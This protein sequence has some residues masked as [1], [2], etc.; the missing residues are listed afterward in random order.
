[1]R[2]QRPCRRLRWNCHTDVK[3]NCARYNT[4][5]E[6]I[7]RMIG[8]APLRSAVSEKT[9]LRHTL[10]SIRFERIEKLPPSGDAPPGLHRPC[11]ARPA[12]RSL[13][14]EDR[15]AEGVR[16]RTEPNRMLTQLQEHDG[17]AQVEQCPCGVRPD[18]TQAAGNEDPSL[19]RCVFLLGGAG[20]R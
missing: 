11:R 15:S 3:D 4:L 13:V 7:R 12:D 9:G 18:R 16:D 19:L 10:P 2:L 1:M 17:F 6:R 20:Q 5:D 8:M 14:A